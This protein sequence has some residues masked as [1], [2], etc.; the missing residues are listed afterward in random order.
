MLAMAPL[1][2]PMVA[3]RKKEL[4]L[5]FNLPLTDSSQNA[6]P[7]DTAQLLMKSTIAKY[8]MLRL[9][10]TKWIARKQRLLIEAL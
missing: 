9:V 2:A 1:S 5:M 7:L 10:V 6:R 3:R 8:W 4:Y